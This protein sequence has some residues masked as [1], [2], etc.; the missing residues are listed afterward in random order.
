MSGVMRAL[1]GSALAASVLAT[2]CGAEDPAREGGAA[3][4]PSASAESAAAGGPAASASGWPSAT[5]AGSVSA[6]AP[7]PP[8]PLPLEDVYPETLE[9]QHAAMF[10]RMRAVLGVT[11]PQVD[12]MKAILAKNAWTGQGNPEVTE[13]ALTRKECRERRA[14]AG[15]V[16]APSHVCGAPNMVPVPGPDGA[17]KVCID[18]YEFPD[19]ACDYPVTWVSAK[20]AHQLCG[21][22]GKRLCDAHEW[23]GA[24]AGTVLPVEVEY[25]FRRG[26]RKDMK[27]F[28]NASR[29]IRWAYGPSQDHA[30]CAT[31]SAKT[32]KCTTQGIG[33][34]RC[35]SN[36]YPAGSFPACR[37]PLGVYDQHG[38]A[39]EHMNLPLKPDQLASTPDGKLG[40]TEMKGSWFIFQKYQAH[41]D[42]CRWRAPDWHASRV[43]VEESHANYH[44][45]F[46]C[47]KDLPGAPAEPTQ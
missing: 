45:G 10:T 30:K 7:P 27:H 31:N 2:G 5:A 34:K 22:L 32:E 29:E 16:D 15:V 42:D 39:A 18:R 33:W 43:M 20:H 9:E 21:A 8:P 25:E 13:Y 1:T 11:E 3:P 35:G 36:T 17:P 40:E 12:A 24:C 23:E 26:S 14:A 19:V 37:S 38:N 46:R 4:A 41:D 28:H 47:C 6:V 44:L